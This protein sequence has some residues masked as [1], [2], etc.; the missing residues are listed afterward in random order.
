[1]KHTIYVLGLAV[2]I[3]YVYLLVVNEIIIKSLKYAT[4]QGIVFE[5]PVLCA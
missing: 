2:C 1:M 3:T 5:F 4:Q